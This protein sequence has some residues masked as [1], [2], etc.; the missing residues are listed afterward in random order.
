ML[1]LLRMWLILPCLGETINWLHGGTGAEKMCCADLSGRGF[2]CGLCDGLDKPTI[3]VEVKI[4]A[5]LILD[6]AY[7]NDLWNGRVPGRP[8]NF[9]HIH[10]EHHIYRVKEGEPFDVGSAEGVSCR[11]PRL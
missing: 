3:F 4:E 10:H 2:A 9:S 6:D 1:A 8:M 11:R 7:W 5:L